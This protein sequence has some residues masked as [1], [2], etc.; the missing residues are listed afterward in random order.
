MDREDGTVTRAFRSKTVVP[1]Q[2]KIVM[3]LKQLVKMQFG[4][5]GDEGTGAAAVAVFLLVTTMIVVADVTSPSTM[6]TVGMKVM[7]CVCSRYMYV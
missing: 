1:V 4:Y 5:V 6:S 3:M 2:I 7:V